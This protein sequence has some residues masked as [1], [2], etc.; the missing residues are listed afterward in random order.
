[1]LLV[2]GAVLASISSLITAIVLK[3][4]Y[5]VTKSLKVKGIIAPISHTFYVKKEAKFLV[6]ASYFSNQYLKIDTYASMA[7]KIQLSTLENKRIDL[8]CN[9]APLTGLGMVDKD[10]DEHVVA[11]IE[12]NGYLSKGAYHLEISGENEGVV[13]QT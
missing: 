7:A 1:M 6:K 5:I 9:A 13:N 12:C 2:A 8:E 11:S 3:P 4:D 10:F